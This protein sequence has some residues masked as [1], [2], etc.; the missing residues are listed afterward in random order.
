M[1]KQGCEL[2]RLQRIPLA[3][4]CSIPWVQEADSVRA[5]AVC[6]IGL[7][8]GFTMSPSGVCAK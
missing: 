5:G 1:A 8:E 2:D 4:E 6:Q 3:A 7:E